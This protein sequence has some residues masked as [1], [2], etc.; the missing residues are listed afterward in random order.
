MS[1]ASSGEVRPFMDRMEELT[2]EALN[3]REKPRGKVMARDD[4]GNTLL[5]IACMKGHFDLCKLLLTHYKTLDPEF[6][7]DERSVWY[8]NVNAR[9]SKGW[10]A[11]SV[12][13]FHCQR[14]I[15]E[16]VLEHGGDPTARKCVW[17]VGLLVWT[18]RAGCSGEYYER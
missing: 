17:K 2:M 6:D 8:C 3:S 16:L 7:K 15:L 1:L 10:N 13:A 18:R 14:T 5:M 9:D 11:T 12:A 4:R